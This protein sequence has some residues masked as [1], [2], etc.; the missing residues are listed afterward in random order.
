MPYLT[1]LHF[2]CKRVD[3]AKHRIEALNP[4]VAIETRSNYGSLDWWD[5]LVES[6]DVVCLTDGSREDLVPLNCFR[7]ANL[8][9]LVQPDA[10]R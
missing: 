9:D 4:L 5:S 1:M 6:V 7:L 10:Y 8:P 2:L 3:A